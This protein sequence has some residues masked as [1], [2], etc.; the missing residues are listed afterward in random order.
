MK[1]P[2]LQKDIDKR[3]QAFD[4]KLNTLDRNQK[5]SK[6]QTIGTVLGKYFLLGVSQIMAF[7]DPAISAYNSCRGKCTKKKQKNT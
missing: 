7:V 3:I 6:L 4:K 1:M 5:S 2:E